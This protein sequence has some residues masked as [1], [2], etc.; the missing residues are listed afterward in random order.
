MTTPFHRALAFVDAHPHDPEAWR[1]LESVLRRYGF[2]ELPEL[3]AMKARAA[4]AAVE[5]YARAAEAIGRI[6]GTRSVR[7]AA[8]KK[9]S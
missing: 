7:D 9:S 4:S 3:V 1:A 6:V 5:D 8:R 2:R